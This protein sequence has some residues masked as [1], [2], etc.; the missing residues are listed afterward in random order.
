LEIDPAVAE[1]HVALADVSKGFD[2]NWHESEISFRRAIEL[3]ANSALAH[4][5][6]A[7]LLSILERH[8]EAVREVGESRE[9]DP[10]SAPAAG[11]VAFTLYRARRFDEALREARK[12]MELNPSSPVVNWFTGLIHLHLGDHER[13]KDALVTAVRE[14]R[15]GAMYLATLAHVLGRAGKPDEAQEVIRSLERK[16]LEQYVSPLDMCIAHAGLDSHEMAIGWLE[17]A[18]AQRVMRVTELG[19]PLYDD[20]REDTRFTA[21]LRRVGLPFRPAALSAGI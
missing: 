7:N 21:L 17:Q 6:Y 20:L 2:W 11:F 14:S 15:D 8:D 19:M 4:H 18:V 10:L 3:N 1:A 12:A 9:I 16:S 5:W 13:A